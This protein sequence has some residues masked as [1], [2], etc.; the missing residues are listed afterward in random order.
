MKL[1]GT[2]IK[3]ILTSGRSVITWIK[4]LFKSRTPQP[5]SQFDKTGWELW[6]QVKDLKPAPKKGDLVDVGAAIKRLMDG[7]EETKTR[8]LFPRSCPINSRTGDGDL[9]G[10]CWHFLLDG[11]TCKIHGDVSEAIKL[12]METGKLTPEEVSNE[13]R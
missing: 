6:Q 13:K 12:Y 7:P 3:T 2:I 11:K 5:I 4:N 1:I 10:R 8:Y 9:V